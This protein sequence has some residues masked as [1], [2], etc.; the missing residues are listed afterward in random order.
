M[1]RLAFIVSHPIQYIAP[2][3]QRLAKRDDIAI[4]VF[5]T[6]HAGET[7]LV[8]RGFGVPVK[9]D[10][11]LTAGYEFELVENT[12]SEPGTHHFTGLRNPRLVERVK[13]WNPTAV[14]IT[15]WAWLSHLQAILAFS[16]S[17]VPVLFRGDSHLLGQPSGPRWWLKRFVLGWIYSRVTA[18]LA[19]GSANR[20][21]FRAFGVAEDRLFQC[22]H[23][24]DVD[25]FAEPEGTLEEEARS[26][27]RELRLPPECLVLLFAAK[28]EHI[29]RPVDF[30]R[31]VQALDEPSI[32]LVMVGAGELEG[33]VRA[34]AE[35]NPEW[36]RLLP[37]QN[38]SRMPVIYRLGDVFVLP[39][40]SETWGLAV[41]EAMA[42]GRPVLVSKN[43]GCAADLV[44]ERAGW[45]FDWGDPES[46]GAAIRDIVR[47]KQDLVAMGNENRRSAWLFDIGRTEETLLSCVKAVTGQ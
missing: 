11:P 41:N 40:A 28:F 29:K 16:R 31:A 10:V 30:M 12:A 43:V 45:V 23:C 35:Q 13:A 47:K 22:P 7:A 25:R 1:T 33:E 5:F 15:G 36:I 26:L 19:V 32:R 9:W 8:D 2:L 37:F 3:Y 44:K 39:S 27:R 34:I 38:Q 42:S 6:W 21:Y 14:H 17:R 18:F 46:L 4:K 20:E 24:I